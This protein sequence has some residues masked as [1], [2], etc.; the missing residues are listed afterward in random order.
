MG[1][2]L[3]FGKI[4]G[5]AELPYQLNIVRQKNTSIA[6]VLARTPLKISFRRSLN[7]DKWVAWVNLVVALNG[8]AHICNLFGI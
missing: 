1:R 5:L 8:S 6:D 3:S 7:G 4:R 2:L